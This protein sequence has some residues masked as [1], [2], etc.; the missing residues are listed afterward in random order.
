MKGKMAVLA[1]VVAVLAMTTACG[2]D[3]MD[4]RV[5]TLNGISYQYH[6]RNLDST[7]KYAK[8]ALTLSTGYPD[9]RAEALNN[10]AFVD[11]AKMKYASASLLLDSVLHETDNQLELLVGNVQLMRLCQRRSDNKNFYHYQ[12]SA[13]ACM[14]RLHEDERLLTQRQRQR[15]VYAESDYSI[16][17]STYYYYV[18]LRKKSAE[19]LDEIDPSGPIVKDTAQLLAYYYNVGTGGLL[20]AKSRDE[21]MQ[22]EFD[23]LMRCYLLSRQYH[24]LFWEANSLQAISEHLQRRDDRMRLTVDNVQELDFLNVDEM[25]DSLLSGNMAQRALNIFEQY[26]D[27]Y[28]TAGAWRTLSEAFFYIGDCQSALSCLD[29]ALYKDTIVNAAPDLVASIREQLSIV[30]S[31]MDN[32]PQSDYNRNLYLDLQ[33]RTRQ[34]RQLEARVEQLDTSLRQLDVMIVVVMLVI[35]VVVGLLVYFSYMRHRNHNDYSIDKLLK[36]F[37]DWKKQRD[38]AYETYDE[39]IEENEEAVAVN[40]NR[41]ARYM[42]RNIEQRAKVWLASSVMPLINRMVHEI[43]ALKYSRESVDVRADRFSYISQVTDSIDVCNQQLTKWIKLRQGDFQLHVESFPVQKLFDMI[44]HN[45]R[46]FGLR[47]VMLDVCASEAVVKADFTLTLFM[48]NTIS[49]NAVR[50]TPKG[51]KVTVSAKEADDYVEISVKDTG[52]GMSEEEAKNVF[53]R[54]VVSD[55]SDTKH[56]GGHGYGL[57]N[58]KGI[59]EKYRKM[60]SLFNVCRI[61]VDSEV[62]NGSRFYFRLPKG[63]V[64]IIV[65]LAIA[66]SFATNVCAVNRNIVPV[67]VQ[68]E[69]ARAGAYADS[70]Y[71]S[72]VN[73]KYK[74]TLVFADSCLKAI[75]SI[76]SASCNKAPTN[77]G[78]LRLDGDYAMAAVELKWFRQN[79]KVDYN[80][81]LDVRNE[82]AVAAL[83]LHKWSLYAYNNAVHTQL[84]RE[85][86]ADNSL[87]LY[88]RTMQRAESSRNMAIIVLVVMLVGIF[89]AYYMLYYR[90]RMSLHRYIDNMNE[91][92]KVL[93]EKEVSS[94]GKLAEIKRIWNNNPGAI[95]KCPGTLLSL[96]ESICSDLADDAQRVAEF[97]QSVV[98]SGDENRRV[99]MDCDRVYVTN[100][101]LDNCLSSLKHETMYYPSRL[102]QLVDLGDTVDNVANIE[103]MANYYQLLYSALISQTVNVLRDGMTIVDVKSELRYLLSILKRKNG[104]KPLD[105]IVNKCMDEEYVVVEV[106]LPGYNYGK[107][108]QGQALTSPECLFATTTPDV[109]FLVCC[110]IM[111][112]LGEATGARACGINA[113][114]TAVGVLGIELKMLKETWTMIASR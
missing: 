108:N 52:C 111:R 43:K 96:Y 71:F 7:Y 4:R 70:A 37:D 49:D 90:H 3:G 95:E 97:Q 84:F 34:D 64:R 56:E 50:Y 104:G 61:G 33:E 82:T 39:V 77:A 105:T 46:N 13:L 68:K 88:V 65:A 98:F 51:G 55:S 14:R 2:H 58:C 75:T 6:Y 114:L 106:A 21:L 36:P 91:I 113:R 11:I 107:G 83:A 28:Q 29:N 109:D 72:N 74:R 17:L 5:D 101:V 30:Y 53:N 10:L 26:G 41:L 79:A 62:G 63:I 38:S 27:V 42:E 31:A 103:E 40:K 67:E 110:Q 85:C 22:S 112:D 48:L 32:K 45:V 12:Q 20:S 80:I 69:Y 25:P 19:A 100:N 9:G 89:P 54:N 94:A 57:M 44:G 16:V 78:Q 99:T 35:V 93:A 81:I 87:P 15:L 92:N 59:I 18:G 76:Y 60:S 102:K 1:V 66:S 8:M 73:G 86:S 47:G 24:Y 23:N